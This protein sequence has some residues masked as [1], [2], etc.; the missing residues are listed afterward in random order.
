M[1]AL[2]VKHGGVLALSACVLAFPYEVPLWMPEILMD[3][4][5]YLHAAPQVQ[6]RTF[7]DI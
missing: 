6:V 1:T 7:S 5:N 4:G 2:C 3:I